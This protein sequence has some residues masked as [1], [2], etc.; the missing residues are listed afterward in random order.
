MESS[1]LTLKLKEGVQ[2]SHKLKYLIKLFDNI[3]DN[4]TKIVNIINQL[5]IIFRITVKNEKISIREF[6]REYYN[7][8]T[9]RESHNN[10]KTH[11][12]HNNLT[13]RES[14]N[15]LT[16][17]E[18]HNIF[19]NFISFFNVFNSVITNQ[20]IKNIFNNKESILPN[21]I[22][23]FYISINK[24]M[25][26]YLNKLEKIKAITSEYFM[27]NKNLNIYIGNIDTS[28]L[29]IIEIITYIKNFLEVMSKAYETNL[30]NQ[31]SRAEELRQAKLREEELK[32][33]SVCSGGGC[34]SS[35]KSNTH[36]SNIKLKNKQNIS[37]ERTTFN[38]YNNFKNVF[39]YEYIQR[40]FPGK[41]KTRSINIEKLEDHITSINGGNTR[42]KEELNK[43]LKGK[44]IN[45]KLTS[46]G[47][48]INICTDKKQ[49]FH[50]SLH[51]KKD[52]SRNLIH[53]IH[54]KV[55]NKVICFLSRNK[56]GKVNLYP[57]SGRITNVNLC[58]NSRQIISIILNLINE[59]SLE[60][61]FK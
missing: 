50:L 48:Y 57:K 52:N 23:K 36:N 16:T 29:N 60:K 33:K 11:E 51:F 20:N 8:L 17:H 59:H 2:L 38:L 40:L 37:E 53:Y 6:I 19:R 15:N 4:I 13:T 24:L 41:I 25:E 44:V 3:K 43:F 34:R 61:Y 22:C 46:T 49:I 54:N 35:S 21:N 28:R 12:S 7:N 42:L 58:Y 45:I 10:L 27:K 39:D 30:I 14:H 1:K 31:E 55:H 32:K 47:F 5:E 26:D 18:S 9:T 56:I